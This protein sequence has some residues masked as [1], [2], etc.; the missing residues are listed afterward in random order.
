MMDYSILA[1]IAKECNNINLWQGIAICAGGLGIL[2]TTIFSGMIT[3]YNPQ[4]T[5][6]SIKPNG[7]E[8][9]TE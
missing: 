6:Q 4:P 1:D 2:G 8:E 7:L 9:R 3:P 5:N